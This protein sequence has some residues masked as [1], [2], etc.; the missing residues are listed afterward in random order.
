MSMHRCT[1]AHTTLA[2]KL[3]CV[4][5]EVDAISP[6]VAVRKANG[7]IRLSIDLRYLNNNIVVE[8][9]PL[10]KNSEMLALTKDMEWFTSID[11]LSAYHQNAQELYKTYVVLK[12]GARD[13]GLKNG[14]VVRVKLPGKV[15][16]GDTKFSEP[17][18][19]LEVYKN[20]AKLSDGRVWHMSRCTKLMGD[21]V[22]ANSTVPMKN[23]LWL[24]SV[25][26]D[27]SSR[28]ANILETDS[29]SEDVMDNYDIPAQEVE[30]SKDHPDNLGR[31]V[32]YRSKLGRMIK[33]PLHLKDYIVN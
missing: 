8:R 24:D 31:N 21:A 12:N 28:A 13:V 30:V 3:R 9:F 23:Y 20:P 25:Y 4:I 14:D 1:R 16:K 27:T 6:L 11:L 10:P 2:P 22:G 15:K 5:E 33:K 7:K 29:A 19:V 18:T 32:T 26:E 17:K